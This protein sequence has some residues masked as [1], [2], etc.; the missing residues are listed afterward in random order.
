MN[1]CTLSDSVFLK[2]MERLPLFIWM[3]LTMTSTGS[4]VYLSV[5]CINREETCKNPMMR[6][7]NFLRF[8]TFPNISAR[9]RKYY[10]FPNQ[11]AN[12]K[13]YNEKGSKAE[14]LRM[15]WVRKVV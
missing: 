8:P 2:I 9:Q 5:F 11:V 14:F 10:L 3:Y 4:G 13:N 12:V 15:I 1:V 7:R 6:I